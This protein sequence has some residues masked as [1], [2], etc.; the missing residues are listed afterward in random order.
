MA[1][2]RNSH[3]IEVARVAVEHVAVGVVQG[4]LQYLVH[5]FVGHELAGLH[6]AARRAVLRL[7]VLVRS[8]GV[9]RRDVVEVV[10][11]TELLRLRPLTGA[12]WAQQ[13]D[14]VVGHIDSDWGRT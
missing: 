3:L 7:H 12:G 14:V 2:S 1:S 13:Q 4:G 6:E 10:L 11:L 8:Q 5:H 9:A